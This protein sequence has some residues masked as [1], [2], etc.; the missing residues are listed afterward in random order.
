MFNNERK[1]NEILDKYSL[2]KEEY[3]FT[4]CRIEP[5]N[6]VHIVLEAFAHS[7]RN[8]LIVGNWEK[9]EYGIH[10]LHQYKNYTNIKCFLQYMILVF[11]I[12]YVLIA[13]FI[14]MGIVREELILL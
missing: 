7:K 10:L 4:V 11:L 3:S 14:Y 6:N 5:E 1:E 8:L 9:N 12:F 13:R 2:R